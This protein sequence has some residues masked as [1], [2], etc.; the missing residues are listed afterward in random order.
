MGRVGGGVINAAL[1]ASST[2]QIHGTVYEFLR[3]TDLNA[4]GYIFGARPATFQKPTMHRNQFGATIGGPLIKDKLFF[5]GDYEGFRQKQG[6]LNFYSVPSGN[7]RI[8]ILPVTVIDPITPGNLSRQYPD[9]G[10][11]AESV[12]GC[13]TLWFGRSQLWSRSH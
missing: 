5:F 2:N 9:T 8:G 6:F 4:I 7:D 11:S 3:N 10:L 1:K 13:G 12:R